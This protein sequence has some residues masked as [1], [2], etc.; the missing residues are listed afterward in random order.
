MGGRTR[1]G[2][3]WELWHR[4]PN[5]VVKSGIGEK[6]RI[7]WMR[8]D[9]IHYEKAAGIWYVNDFDRE[10]CVW[11]PRTRRQT[12]IIR[13]LNDWTGMAM[14]EKKSTDWNELCGHHELNDRQ[15]SSVNSTIE[16]VWQCI[17]KHLQNEMNCVAATNSTTNNNHP[18]T[19]RLNWYDNAFFLNLRNEVAVIDF[20]SW[21]FQVFRFRFQPGRCSQIWQED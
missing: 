13:E 10:L 6:D 19:Q 18:W 15:Q 20:S 11:P 1:L 12:T 16:L 3:W 2:S 5:E 9:L 14:H 8:V 7:V 17:L 21:F 4:F